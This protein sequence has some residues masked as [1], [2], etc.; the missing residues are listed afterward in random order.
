MFDL[1]LSQRMQFNDTD[2]REAIE[3]AGTMIELLLVARKGGILSIEWRVES[4]NEP[5]LKIG[6]TMAVDMI[7]VETIKEILQNYIMAGDYRGGALLKRI[8]I[9]DGILGLAVGENPRDLYR[10][11]ASRFGE[12]FF[13][14]YEKYCKPVLDL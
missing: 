1:W 9:L 8:I 14:E 6:L 4:C 5:L 12:D 2:R 10:I 3:V 7:D 13:P 11:L